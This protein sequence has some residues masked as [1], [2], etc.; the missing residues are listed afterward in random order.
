M[1]SQF[2]NGLGGAFLEKLKVE[3]DG[4]AVCLVDTLDL[5]LLKYSFIDD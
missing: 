5:V 3:D 2:L 4:H 1:K